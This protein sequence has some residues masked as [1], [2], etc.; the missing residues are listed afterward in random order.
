[1]LNHPTPDRLTKLGFDGM[2][3]AQRLLDDRRRRA[4]IEGVARM[5]M[6]QQMVRG[7]QRYAVARGRRFDC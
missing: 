5:G 7:F 6:T 4:A 1:L 3:I 2:A